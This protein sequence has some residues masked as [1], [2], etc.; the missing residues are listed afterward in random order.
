MIDPVRMPVTVSP[1]WERALEDEPPIRRG[2]PPG[3]LTPA[4]ERRS[5]DAETRAE[6]AALRAQMVDMSATLDAI[7]QQLSRLDRDNLRTEQRDREILRALEEAR[8]R[9]DLVR[10]ALS[11]LCEPRI[12]WWRRRGAR[13]C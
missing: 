3:A 13:D 4:A 10:A 6:V 5:L 8:E 9:D 12:A 1:T 11:R 2:L 7:R